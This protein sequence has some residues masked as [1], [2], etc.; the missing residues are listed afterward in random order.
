V[1]EEAQ[2]VLHNAHEPH[3]VADLFDADV[4]ASEHG[5][6]VDLAW[7][8]LGVGL[9]GGG[10]LG[11]LECRIEPPSIEE[12]AA[13]DAAAPNLA[14]YSG[15]DCYLGVA[16]LGEPRLAI[17]VA[18]GCPTGAEDALGPFQKIAATA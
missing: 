7:K 6:Q 2:I 8:A 5:A 17:S 13:G 16:W 18:S 3:L 9:A 1:I 4:L 10:G 15:R 11:S 12:R 14:L